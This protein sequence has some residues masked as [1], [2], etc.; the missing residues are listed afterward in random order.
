[1]GKNGKKALYGIFVLHSRCLLTFFLSLMFTTVK[2]KYNSKVVQPATLLTMISLCLWGLFEKVFLMIF[3]YL[4]SLQRLASDLLAAAGAV[5]RSA[6]KPR[7]QLPSAAVKSRVMK[8][9]RNAHKRA[10]TKAW[11]LLCESNPWLAGELSTRCHA[12][13]WQAKDE[14]NFLPI[15]VENFLNLFHR[16]PGSRWPECANKEVFICA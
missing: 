16:T 3:F 7:L 5:E 9:F 10:R 11:K 13:P 2:Q 1:M 14:I 12:I 8:S 15:G 4:F 6:L